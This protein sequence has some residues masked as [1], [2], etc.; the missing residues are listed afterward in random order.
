M[1]RGVPGC[2]QGVILGSGGGR[3]SVPNRG[4]LGAFAEGFEPSAL[5]GDVIKRPPH[6]KSGATTW[7]P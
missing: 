3:F 7:V 5:L 1:V 4:P 6:V 2:G